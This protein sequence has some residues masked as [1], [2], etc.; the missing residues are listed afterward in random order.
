MANNS[1][2]NEGFVLD[3]DKKE[4]VKSTKTKKQFDFKKFKTPIII[5][6]SVIVAVALLFTVMHFVSSPWRKGEKPMPE[7]F[8]KIGVGQGM[9]FRYFDEVSIN[10]VDVGGMTKNQAKRAIINAQES[11]KSA[12]NIKITARDKSYQL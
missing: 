6:A 4:K 11:D 3:E 1:L 2:K 8:A 7:F 12:Y 10:G 5:G 9:G